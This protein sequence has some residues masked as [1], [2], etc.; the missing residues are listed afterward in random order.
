VLQVVATVADFSSVEAEPTWLG[1]NPTRREQRCMR[2][3]PPG[4]HGVDCESGVCGVAPLARG[5]HHGPRSAPSI[6]SLSQPTRLTCS[7]QA[8]S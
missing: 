3:K 6:L 2:E 8:G 4:P 1:L 7:T 5:I